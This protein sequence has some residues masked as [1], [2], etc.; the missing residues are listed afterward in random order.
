MV[1]GHCEICAQYDVKICMKKSVGHIL[2]PEGPF[3]HLVMDYVDMIKSVQGKRY[4]LV[5]TDRF[6]GWVEATPSKKLSAEI[7]VKFLI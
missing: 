4:I 2:V 7:A 3:K 1:L 6:S 5:I